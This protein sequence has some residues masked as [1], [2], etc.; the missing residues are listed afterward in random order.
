[1]RVTCPKHVII[2][3]LTVVILFGE[4]HKLCIYSLYSFSCPVTSHLH[5]ITVLSA[6]CL[7]H[8]PRYVTTFRAHIT[9]YLL[10]CIKFRYAKTNVGPFAVVSPDNGARAHT[11]THTHT[12]THKTVSFRL[13]DIRA[14]ANYLNLTDN[15]TQTWL[16]RVTRR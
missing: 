9:L 13:L 15:I 14:V 16:V 4:K 5:G 8:N 7:N 11:R 1:M 3:V 12:H 6:N 2:L 10:P